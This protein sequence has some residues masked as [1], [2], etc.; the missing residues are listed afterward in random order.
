VSDAAM[1]VNLP[2]YGEMPQLL[3][4]GLFRSLLAASDLERE[5]YPQLTPSSETSAIS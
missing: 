3:R 4:P 2:S 5:H 1:S